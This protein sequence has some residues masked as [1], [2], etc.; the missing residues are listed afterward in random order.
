VPPTTGGGAAQRN[1][2]VKLLSI[3]QPWASL[4][5]HGIKDIENRTW[6][7]AYRGPLL[8]HA[9]LKVDC[10]IADVRRSLGIEVPDLRVPIGGI[11]G[12]TNVIDCVEQYSSVWFRGPFGFV[13]NGSRPQPFLEMKG[14]LKLRD[15][16][17]SVLE[18]YALT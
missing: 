1:Y 14:A 6:R 18:R 11:V 9:S 13:L 5:A 16:P 3:R 12:I 15:V 17:A 7:T 4:I 8:I 2:P 10:S